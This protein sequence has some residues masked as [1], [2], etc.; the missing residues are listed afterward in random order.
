MSEI[1][2]LCGT[3]CV[4]YMCACG[5][6]VLEPC[7]CF[8][9]PEWLHCAPVLPRACQSA[10][11]PGHVSPERVGAPLELCEWVSA[12]VLEWRPESCLA[13]DPGPRLHILLG[14]GSQKDSD[15]KDRTREERAWPLGL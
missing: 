4:S 14:K 5:A 12:F 3:A 10:Q 7:C 6:G 1:Q 9:S 15:Q 8:V 2:R 11:T 13:Q